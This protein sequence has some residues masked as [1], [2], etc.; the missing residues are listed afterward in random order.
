MGVGSVLGRGLFLTLCCLLWVVSYPASASVSQK[1]KLGPGDVVFLEVDAHK[2]LT[3]TFKLRPSGDIMVPFVGRVKVGGLTVQQARRVLTRRLG[4]YFR[5]LGKVRLRVVERKKFVWIKGWVKQPGRY[6]L[7]SD[8]G[9]EVLLRKSGGVRA[10]ARLDALWV[11]SPGKAPV[12]F[13]LLKYYQQGARHQA[14]ELV[15]GSVVFVPVSGRQSPEVGVRGV[16]PGTSELAILGAVRNP[17]VY[18]CY[19]KVSLLHALAMTGG[20]LLKSKLQEVLITPPKGKTFWFDLKA[21][22]KGTSKR[23]LPKLVPGT[24]VMVPF[25][26]V[27]RS[28]R[29]PVR[30]L[31]EVGRPGEW[32]GTH[33]K[34]LTGWLARVGGPTSNADMSS[35]SVV[36]KASNFT[37]HQEVDVKRALK[38][39]RPNR[40]PPT[41]KGRLV[42]Y[43]PKKE[44]KPQSVQDFQNILQ[45][46]IAVTSVATSVVLLVTTLAPK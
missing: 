37:I 1:G 30:I 28:G 14:V 45:I 41:G 46:A 8:D 39:G 18:P 12:K 44:S 31:G 43:V 7:R 26:V 27:G 38:E 32:R 4:T 9:V 6:L 16:R 34:Q 11:H 23:P 33:E 15:R 25:E 42:I 5:D 20:P 13:N 19:W 40:L 35:V 10:G 36:Y 3:K 29:G 21:Y 22:Y 17:G 24:V 2:S